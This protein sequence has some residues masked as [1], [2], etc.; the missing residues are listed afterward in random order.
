MILYDIMPYQY[1]CRAELQSQHESR[2]GTNLDKHNLR[3]CGQSKAAFSYEAVVVW[4]GVT[5]Y[6]IALQ[7]VDY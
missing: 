3:L 6:G 5:M 7:S 4:V 1:P 2:E